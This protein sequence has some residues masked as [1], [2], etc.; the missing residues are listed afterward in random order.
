MKSSDGGYTKTALV[1]EEEALKGDW[2]CSQSHDVVGASKTTHAYHGVWEMTYRSP[3]VRPDSKS[4]W[5]TAEV[6]WSKLSYV[7]DFWTFPPLGPGPRNEKRALDGFFLRLE[8]K[9]S[10][11][12]S[13]GDD[14]VPMMTICA[15]D[16]SLE[17]ENILRDTIGSSEVLPAL[18]IY[19]TVHMVCPEI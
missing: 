18:C 4:R 17:G 1:W 6:S 13:G 11:N 12:C 7:K 15:T 3:L 2:E 10:S 16:S 9:R 8:E 14:E 19:R 5:P